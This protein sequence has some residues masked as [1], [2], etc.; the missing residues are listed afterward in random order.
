MS[1]FITPV[2]YKVSSMDE[3][4]EIEQEL[5]KLGYKDGSSKRIINHKLEYHPFMQ[6][7]Y[8]DKDNYSL[9]AVPGDR[10]LVNSKEEFLKLA[11]QKEDTFVLP[12]NWCVLRTMDNHV[13]INNWF[14]KNGYGAPYDNYDYI[15]IVGSN[16]YRTVNCIGNGYIPITFE[17]F[18]KYVL[19]SNNK[20]TKTEMKHTVNLDQLRII[21]EIACANW[22]EKIK[23]Y[24]GRAVFPQVTV[25][26][27]DNEVKAMYDASSDS[28]KATLDK[29]FTEYKKDNNPFIFNPDNAETLLKLSLGCFGSEDA[30]VLANDSV[31]YAGLNLEIYRNR[32][33][34]VDNQYKVILHNG[35]YGN[36]VIEFQNK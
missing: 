24:A 27:T 21:Y 31:S 20:Q 3:A 19:N 8:T 18:E 32:C 29:I 30:I 22:Q 10:A 17:Q 35:A 2:A 28:Q 33:L 36:T 16:S 26:F 12:E 4:L 1:K 7:N 34:S 9:Y 11:A 25:D 6:T 23:V 15:G 14:N 13:V 5:I